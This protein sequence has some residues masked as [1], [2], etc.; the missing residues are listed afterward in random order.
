MDPRGAPG[1]PRVTL[2]Y[3]SLLTFIQP[4]EALHVT[5]INVYMC[6]VCMHITHIYIYRNMKIMKSIIFMV[7]VCV[8]VHIYMTN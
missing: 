3:C 5:V 6:Y 8:S 7:I 4:V 2:T 1:P